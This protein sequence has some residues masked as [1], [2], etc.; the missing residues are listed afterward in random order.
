MIVNLYKKDENTNPTVGKLIDKDNLKQYIVDNYMEYIKVKNKQEL[1]NELREYLYKISDLKSEE[2]NDVI[3]KTMDDIFGYGI[4]QQFIECKDI[5]DIRAI[6]YCSIYVKKSGKWSKTDIKFDSEEEYLKYIRYSIL[7]N[8]GII[9]YDKPINIVSD[10]SYNL[11]IE[12][13]ISPVNTISPNIVIRIHRNN[14]DISLEKLYLKDNMMEC[15]EYLFLINAIKNK[16]NII[17]SGK[18]GSGKTTLLRALLEKIP[19]EIPMT[20]NEESTEIYL[21][22]KNAIQREIIQTREPKKN[23]D[24]DKLMK[25]SL[26]MSNDVLVVGE[27]KG[28][29]ETVSLIDA[30]NTGHTGY[31]TIHSNSAKDTIDRLVIL[32]KKDPLT[33]TYTT[34]F[35]E[36]IMCK[37]IDYIV[38][39]KDYKIDEIMDL[40]YSTE[41]ER[42]D[43]NIIYKRRGDEY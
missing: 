3:Y 1:S 17:I 6:D 7:K 34:D 15:E 20:I 24:L 35:I 23:I 9:N 19:N 18:G 21:K 8:N 41:N 25:H 14:L 33:Q 31:A 30:I 28:G 16:K 38:F 37:N 2:I 27:L 4:L 36:K 26:V 22:N 29:A 42:C 5:T 10:K 13:G 11:R 32:F 43:F 39:L 12:A 40:K